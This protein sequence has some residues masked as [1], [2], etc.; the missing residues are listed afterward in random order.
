MPVHYTKKIVCLANSRKPGGRCIAGRE[1]HDSGFG[2][3]V[4]PVSIRSGAEVSLDERRYENG[5]EPEIL[6]VLSVPMIAPVPKLHQT[7]NHILDAEHY[8]AKEG[9]LAWNDLPSLADFP[10]ALWLKEG[11]TNHG[12]N[13]CVTA[14]STTQLTGSLFLIRQPKLDVIVKVEVGMLV[15][16]SEGC[17]QVFSTGVQPIASW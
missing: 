3:W 13:D 17:G 14:A 9:A 5:A 7:E 11:S 6:D 8:W 1:V 4:R 12:V 10:T 2:G 16:P 15:P